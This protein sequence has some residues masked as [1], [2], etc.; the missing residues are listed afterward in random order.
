MVAISDVLL[1][2]IRIV[3]RYGFR[4]VPS[5]FLSKDEAALVWV[6]TYARDVSCHGC[7]GMPG[8]HVYSEAVGT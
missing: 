1:P 2:F 4:H 7:P 3:L 8:N 5:E 6:L